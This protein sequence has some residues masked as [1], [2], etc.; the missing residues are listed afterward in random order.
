MKAFYIYFFY[1]ILNSSI[2]FSQSANWTTIGS[3]F[4]AGINMIDIEPDGTFIGYISSTGEL[5]ISEDNGSSWVLNDFIAAGG[6]IDNG[7]NVYI[8]K[9]SENGTYDSLIRYSY[10]N[11]ISKILKTVDGWIGNYYVSPNGYY[12]LKNGFRINAFNADGDSLGQATYFSDLLGQSFV[13]GGTLFVLEKSFGK[14]N[15]EKYN[16]DN[17]FTS[18]GT[19]GS[20]LLKKE[21]I[22]QENG[23][24]YFD[25][26]YSTDFGKTQI[27]ISGLPDE[28]VLAIKGDGQGNVIYFYKEK[29]F[30]I[31]NFQVDQTYTFNYGLALKTLVYENKAY[32]SNNFPDYSTAV[33]D[34]ITENVSYFKYADRKYST[35][36]NCIDKENVIHGGPNEVQI[37]NH[38]NGNFVSMKNILRNFIPVFKNKDTLVAV[39]T[40]YK[41]IISYNGGITWDTFLNGSNLSFP[42]ITNNVKGVYLVGYNK[43]L[44]YSN[45]YINF[46]EKDIDYGYGDYGVTTFNQDYFR[47]QQ[48]AEWLLL[49]QHRGDDTKYLTDFLV[50][51]DVKSSKYDNAIYTFTH[52]RSNNICSIYKIDESNKFRYSL[53]DNIE[54]R[55]LSLDVSPKGYLA[56]CTENKVYLKS[57]DQTPWQDITP[58]LTVSNSITQVD[59]SEDNYLF[60]STKANGVLR[61]NEKL[62]E[63]KAV[64]I[65]ININQDQ[66]CDIHDQ[67]L[68]K[69]YVYGSQNGVKY[70]MDSL[71]YIVFTTL[72]S[73]Y[74]VILHQEGK[75]EFCKDTIKGTLANDQIAYHEVD[76]IETIKCVDLKLEAGGHAKT[77]QNYVYGNCVVCNYGNLPSDSINSLIFDFNPELELAFANS[78]YIKISPTQYKFK[79]FL[80]LPGQCENIGLSLKLK[81]DQPLFE[82]LCL[83][84]SLE[85]TN[86]NHCNPGLQSFMDCVTNDEFDYN[87]IVVT[88]FIDE[89]N[90]CMYDSTEMEIVDITKISMDSTTLY[91]CNTLDPIVGYTIKPE[92]QVSLFENNSDLLE[93]CFMDT[94]INFNNS[95]F[96]SLKIPVKSNMKCAHVTITSHSFLRYCNKGII[97]LRVSNTGSVSLNDDIIIY[98]KPDPNATVISLTPFNYTIN[99][100]TL[101]IN[102]GKLKIAESK[103]IHMQLDDNCTLPLGSTYLYEAWIDN[104]TP[105]CME[106]PNEV[107]YIPI[108]SR[109]PYDPNDKSTLIN[110]EA[111]ENGILKSDKLE[112]LI[113]FQNTGNDTAYHVVIRDTLSN[114][115]DLN[116][117]EFSSSSHP[118]YMF[119]N[120]NELIF[121]FDNINLVDSF[122]NEPLSHG[123]IRFK[124]NL[125]EDLSMPSKINNTAS[126][127]FDLNP[128]IY[129]NTT[130]NDY[131]ITHITDQLQIS[132]TTFIKLSPN[133]V[134][135]KICIDGSFDAN[136]TIHIMDVKGRSVKK[137]PYEPC[138]QLSALTS[139]TYTL[140]L[141][142]K[143]RV[144]I[145][146]FVKV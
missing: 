116:S 84:Y 128:P 70:L 29:F 109:G 94:L 62:D 72:E 6:R 12:F 61:Y 79:P 111:S 119:L 126:I 145:G 41:P 110:D 78:D 52:D 13:I 55:L 14:Y 59:F 39:N 101:A 22:Y 58:S 96:K 87:S 21:I 20:F 120:G 60:L 8:T 127:Y 75:Y 45:D 138:I 65:K 30:K 83:Q 25:K 57:D 125:R 86:S 11:N 100:N 106:Y 123:Y 117:I 133:P 46:T 135:E 95:K 38:T 4:I 76:M 89:D 105:L 132:S 102:I 92:V 26:Y 49:N 28:D 98:L 74:E 122:T 3:P 63:R 140:L 118:V 93:Y 107:H 16:I 146:K 54:G 15:F 5:A 18:E 2:V 71:G 114:A 121:S 137:L 67:D 24:I 7:G 17:Q 113:R 51:D 82:K 131:L 27:E 37:V 56:V 48:L 141:Y 36:I 136:S 90:D 91:Q 31:K 97:T 35:T 112:Y 77:N 53:L 64:V 108:K 103:D 33:F 1:L 115:F 142:E 42:S 32:I 85:I 130:S 81:P 99:G 10:N 124:I 143:E 144:Y 69:G 23:V 80:L 34:L 19:V 43:K 129:T 134:T 104:P 50:F 9:R 139:G 44:Y 88:G 68:P 47:I 66:D 40:F 73:S